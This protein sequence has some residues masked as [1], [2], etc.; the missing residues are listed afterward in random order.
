MHCVIHQAWSQ[1]RPER[2][3]RCERYR[4]KPA[5]RVATAS[6]AQYTQKHGR[7]ERDATRDAPSVSVKHY[8]VLHIGQDQTNVLKK[9]GPE[10]SGSISRS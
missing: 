5:I 2:T 3:I 1:Q 4:R 10:F 9:E 6:S 8:D 7:R